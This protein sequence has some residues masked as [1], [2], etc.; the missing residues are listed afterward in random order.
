MKKTCYMAPVAEITDIE[1]QAM[2]CN[3]ITT[4][5][6]DTDITPADPDDEI[7][8]KAGTRQHLD[9]WDDEGEELGVE[10]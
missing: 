10:E 1:L 4:V 2:V 6:G 7:P 9:V 3:T 8:G 5:A